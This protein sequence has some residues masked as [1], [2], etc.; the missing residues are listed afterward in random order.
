[1]QEHK[2][3]LKRHNISLAEDAI[4]ETVEE[5]AGLKSEQ[6]LPKQEIMMAA[7]VVA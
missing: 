5:M 2:M 3:P 4:R 7:M 1:M 6:E